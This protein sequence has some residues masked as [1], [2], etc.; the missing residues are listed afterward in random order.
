MPQLAGLKVLRAGP[1]TPIILGLTTL[2]RD[3][4]RVR[5]RV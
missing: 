5:V 1:C 2:V 4:V 3:R